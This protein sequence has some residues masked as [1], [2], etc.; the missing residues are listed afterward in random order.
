MWIILAALGIIAMLAGLLIKAPD[1]RR[2]L[3]FLGTLLLVAGLVYG[4]LTALLLGGID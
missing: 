1:T 4:G 2:T 3:L